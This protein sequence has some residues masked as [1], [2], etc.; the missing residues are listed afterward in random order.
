MPPAGI[1]RGLGAV[2]HVHVWVIIPNRRLGND[3]VWDGEG[4]DR[5]NDKGS[6]EPEE[7]R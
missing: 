7:T 3:D 5:V 6:W 2:V 1:L 4:G